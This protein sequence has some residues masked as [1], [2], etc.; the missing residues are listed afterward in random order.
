MDIYTTGSERQYTERTHH[1]DFF[2]YRISEPGES[3]AQ[4]MRKSPYYGN[5][6]D[7]WLVMFERKLR[8]TR[9]HTARAVFGWSDFTA[10]AHRARV[11]V[12]ITEVKRANNSVSNN[13]RFRIY[14]TVDGDSSVWVTET[15]GKPSYE[16]SNYTNSR[17]PETYLLRPDRQY[18][19]VL[20]PAGRVRD[21]EYQGIPLSEIERRAYGN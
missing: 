5:K 4:F 3:F 11:L 17:R 10:T 7:E 6:P 19:L 14:G 16:V 2:A 12:R 8:P 20:T 13:P 21:I 15:D 1:G 9:D 18:T